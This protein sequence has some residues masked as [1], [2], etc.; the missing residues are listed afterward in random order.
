MVDTDHKNFEYF[1]Q[2]K[3]F[4]RCEARWAELLSEFN[5]VIIF[6]SGENNGEADALPS[7]MDTMSDERICHKFRYLNQVSWYFWNQPSLES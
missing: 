1:Q 3:I 4:N 2:M 5:F 6:R 7:W